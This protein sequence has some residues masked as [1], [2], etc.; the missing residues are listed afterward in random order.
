M[1]NSIQPRV[2]P[3][4]SPAAGVADL[5]TVPASAR[6]RARLSTRAL[7]G[8]DNEIE[9]QHGEAIYRLRIT[10]LGKLILTK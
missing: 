10:S 6:C 2:R 5:G 3:P 8:A 4:C 1:A 9:I 7:F